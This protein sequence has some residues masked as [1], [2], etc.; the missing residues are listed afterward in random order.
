MLLQAWPGAAAAEYCAERWA[1]PK[2]LHEAT[3]TAEACCTAQ[4]ATAR[5][6]T[7]L[8]RLDCVLQEGVQGTPSFRITL[9]FSHQVAEQRRRNLERHHCNRGGGVAASKLGVSLPA[10][11]CGWEACQA[12][13]QV[14]VGSW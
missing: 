4:Q 14:V 8:D 10:Q 7:H 2:T 9:G 1:N 6:V 3:G 12:G 11:W 5:R 13:W